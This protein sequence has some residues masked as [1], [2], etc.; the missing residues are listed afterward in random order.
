[1]NEQETI[2]CLRSA[3]DDSDGKGKSPASLVETHSYQPKR[4]ATSRH[5]LR[6]EIFSG[7]RVENTK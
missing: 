3:N 1:M 7:T 6:L 2:L 5:A 4:C